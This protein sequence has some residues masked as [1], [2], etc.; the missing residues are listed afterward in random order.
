MRN[1]LNFGGVVP[2]ALNK[3]FMTHVLLPHQRTALHEMRYTRRQQLFADGTV[4]DV[5]A[6]IT[7][8]RKNILGFFLA[9]PLDWGRG[10]ETKGD[11]SKASLIRVDVAD[12]SSKEQDGGRST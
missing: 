11:P 8:L 12:A 5:D 1:G 7:Y 3:K 9:A 2:P 10:H 6:A 4:H